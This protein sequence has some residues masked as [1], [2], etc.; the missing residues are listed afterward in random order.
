MKKNPDAQL[1]PSFV[2]DIRI[3]PTINERGGMLGH[4]T[5]EYRNNLLRQAN[6]PVRFIWR[7]LMGGLVSYSF[8]QTIFETDASR[9]LKLSIEFDLSSRVGRPTSWRWRLSGEQRTYFFTQFLVRDILIENGRGNLEH[10]SMNIP[11]A[12]APWNSRQAALIR[13][14]TIE[15]EKINGSATFCKVIC[16]PPFSVQYV[17][18]TD[19][20]DT[21]KQSKYKLR[22]NL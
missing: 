18:T 7:K 17:F 15:G 9:D 5:S 1:D 20:R 3:L 19:S 21:L 10:V 2:V 12:F 11:I 14:T 16:R 8:A 6:I 13:S 4:V 22:N